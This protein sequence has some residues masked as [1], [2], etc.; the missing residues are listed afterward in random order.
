MA[1][2]FAIPQSMN[3]CPAETRSAVSRLVAPAAEL[4]VTVGALRD[5]VTLGDV[6]LRVTGL[7]V[8]VAGLL[9]PLAGLGHHGRS[10][11]PTGLRRVD[12]PVVTRTDRHR[13]WHDLTRRP[14]LAG[15]GHGLVWRRAKGPSRSRVV[16]HPEPGSRR[17]RRRSPG[18]PGHQ[19]RQTLHRDPRIT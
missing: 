18:A 12:A 11:S 16:T 5:L 19:L 4:A 15:S 3:A 1:R 14:R 10:S 6:D 7:A 13:C 8:E 9:A 2:D 17:P